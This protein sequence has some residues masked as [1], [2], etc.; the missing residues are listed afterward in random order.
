MDYSINRA[1]RDFNRI[2]ISNL[3]IKTKNVIHRRLCIVYNLKCIVIKKMRL[4]FHIYTVFT[5]HK[6]IFIEN[7]LNSLC[8]LNSMSILPS[9]ITWM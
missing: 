3:E 2:N 8:G 7:F 9:R 4:D 5:K 6:E 1:N